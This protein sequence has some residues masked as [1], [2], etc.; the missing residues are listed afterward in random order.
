MPV[1]PVQPLFEGAL[2]IVGD[3]H[4]ELPALNSLLRQLGYDPHG[5]HPRGRRLVFVGDLCDRGPDSPGVLFFVR[6]LMARGLAQCVLGN[7][8][9]YLLRNER[10]SGNGW[11]FDDHPDHRRAEFAGVRR[12]TARE[13]DAARIFAA[14]LPLALQRIDLR[15]THAV[16]DQSLLDA[17]SGAAD[18]STLD[19]YLHFEQQTLQ[20]IAPDLRSAAYAEKL[21]FRDALYDRDASMPFLPALAQ[22]DELYQMGNP[23][24]VITSGVERSTD[25]RSFFAGGKWRMVERVPWWQSYVEPVPV[26]VGHFWR[27]YSSEGQARYARDEGDLFGGAAPQ[28]W[29]DTSG[30]VYCTD[31]SVGARFLELRDGIAPGTYT[32]LAAVRWPEREVVFENGERRELTA[33]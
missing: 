6:K 14:A 32:R 25:G 4:G 31:F 11:Y 10:K 18:R 21:R 29:L 8:E 30:R 27:W 1:Q 17:L 5:E 26:I 2:D 7:H 20:R 28:Q 13:R 15:V 23:V 33:R 22:E 9:L 3:V 19:S 12:A 24:R 16:W